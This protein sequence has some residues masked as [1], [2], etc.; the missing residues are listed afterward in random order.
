MT[1]R[2]YGRKIGVPGS[3]PVG[4]RPCRPP[5]RR[6]T[7]VSRRRSSAVNEVSARAV[8]CPSR[9]VTTPTTCGRPRAVTERRPALVVHEEERHLVRAGSRGPASRP[10]SAA[11]PTSPRPWSRRS[12]RAGRRPRGRPPRFRPTPPRAPRVSSRPSLPAS[13]DARSGID[14]ATRSEQAGPR[15]EDRS[16]LP[17][18]RPTLPQRCER[19][20]HALDPW[21][22][23]QIRLQGARDPVLRLERP[24]LRPP[25]TEPASIHH[26]HCTTR[27]SCARDVPQHHSHD[28][29]RRPAAQDRLACGGVSGD[30]PA[31][32]HQTTRA[33]P[34]RS[35]D[36]VG[37]LTP[38]DLREQ[39]VESAEPAYGHRRPGSAAGGP[40]E[41]PV[42][43]RD[44]I[45]DDHRELDPP[46][47][48]RCR[49][50][51]AG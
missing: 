35:A 20:G 40:D 41:A 51:P 5:R 2:G 33:A 10:A 3:V 43:R 46:R 19:T 27:G 21:A 7:A 8:S 30:R 22:P 48:D 13:A 16:S 12:A 49:P 34:R 50:R 39:P 14:P 42:L 4:T 9:S 45:G 29:D 32:D 44:R 6:R 15:P 36:S 47:W 23:W 1:S 37:I 24:P 18:R 11:A 28:A 38:A 17:P 25:T 26:E 31:V